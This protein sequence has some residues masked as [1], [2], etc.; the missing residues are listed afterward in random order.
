MSSVTMGL[1]LGCALVFV[2]QALIAVWYKRRFGT[3]LRPSARTSYFD[4][5]PLDLLLITSVFGV[6]VVVGLAAPVFWPHAALAQWLRQPYATVVY[7]ACC[8]AGM[9]VLTFAR[10]V[11]IVLWVARRG[12]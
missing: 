1:A 2:A 5:V 9:F 3:L 10:A 7:F 11:A 8:F 12:R 4:N 6:A